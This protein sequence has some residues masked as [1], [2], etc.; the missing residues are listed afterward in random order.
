[1]MHDRNNG[2]TPFES[3]N[4]GQAPGL[5]P[6]SLF[7]VM[8]RH[9]WTIIGCAFLA[10]VAGFTYL[11]KA[12][13]IYTSTASIYVEQTGPRILGDMEEGVMTG[14]Q[15]YLYTQAKLITAS[16]IILPVIN[17]PDIKKL[18]TF[19]NV[20]NPQ[21][22]L[23]RSLKA[24]V[25]KKD[26]LLEISI[27]SPYPDDASQIVNEVVAAYMDFHTKKKRSTATEVLTLLQNEKTVRSKELTDSLQ[28]M[29]K[30]KNENEGLSLQT[31]SGTNMILEG[32]NRTSYAL[33]D[34][35]LATLEA[36]SLY[37]SAKK[38]VSEPEGLR[39]FIEAQ[40]VNRYSSFNTEKTQLTLQLEM[41]KDRLSD[42]LRLLTPNHPSVK[43]LDIEVMQL[44]AK[45][46][47]MDDNFVNAQL[48]M[49]EQQYLSRKEQEGEL[50]KD[51]DVQKA[52]VLKLSKEV[53]EFTLLQSTYDQIRK[54]C[55][56]LD[57][58]IKELNVTE[59]AGVLNITILESAIPA[60]LD[61]PSSPQKA[62]IMAMVLV[63]GLMF[64]GG[65]ALLRDMMDH[66]IHS[67]E[68]VAKLLNAPVLG[69]VPSM[70]KRLS[71][72]DRGKNVHLDTSS[73]ISEA[74]RTIRT[75]VFFS[76]PEDQAKI[77]QLTSP[78]QGEGKS[79]LTSNLAIAMAQS[80]QRVL[81]I[82][83]DFRRPTQHVIF[84]ITREKGLS[85][86]IA[87]MQIL[88]EAVVVSGISGLDL[89]PCG[90]DVPNPAEMLGSQ[91]FKELLGRLRDKYDRILIDSTPLLPVADATIL[92]TVSDATVLVVRAENSTGKA[93]QQAAAGIMSVGGRL[94]GA[95]I[96]DVKPGKNG[97]SYGYGYG[98]EPR[99][100]Q[101]GNGRKMNAKTQSTGARMGSLKGE[102]MGDDTVVG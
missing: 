71:E 1:M 101:S 16:P 29:M 76:V 91:A 68:E 50:V 77:I 47:Q 73:V 34:A 31:S 99:G 36:K 45:L 17:N 33:N 37:Q 59:D 72:A 10:L 51:F 26:D 93:I 62:R 7:Q 95:V 102:I 96:N 14:S 41:L 100:K 32:L 5:M 80:G 90:P 57:D 55:D 11:A 8:W 6:E 84:E 40:Q 9:S 21:E 58:R 39:Q 25:G 82:D 63:L 43:A 87:G 81:I 53:S 19:A 22:F 13:P 61:N 4:P 70:S 64:G 30:F 12:T 35:H 48:A 69:T 65:F 89:L 92:A 98:Y 52:D 46:A 75:A 60:D 2:L 88:E 15:N 54:T 28:A 56:I 38:M 94:I 24:A 86:V 42:R 3:N 74:Y 18:R 85:G 23:K 79:T 49:L 83:G 66:R 27:D 97:Y 78:M 20:Q 44:E 67:S